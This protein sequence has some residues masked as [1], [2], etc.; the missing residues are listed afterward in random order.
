ML[1]GT[2]GVDISGKQVDIE[3]PSDAIN[4]DSSGPIIFDGEVYLDPELLPR[5]GLGGYQETEQFKLCACMP[6]GTLYRIRVSEEKRF[7]CDNPDPEDWQFHPC[8]G[9]RMEK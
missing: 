6:G 7:T 5:G 3:A 4:L 2:E 9:K 8:S 1:L